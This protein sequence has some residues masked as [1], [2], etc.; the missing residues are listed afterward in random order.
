MLLHQHRHQCPIEHWSGQCGQDLHS[1]GTAS[2]TKPVGTTGIQTL[3]RPPHIQHTGV[4]LSQYWDL[5]TQSS[6]G[7]GVFP[8]THPCS[9]VPTQTANQRRLYHSTPLRLPVVPN[10]NRA[11]SIPSDGPTTATL[12]QS[13]VGTTIG[14][15]ASTT[16]VAHASQAS[17]PT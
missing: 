6:C 2:G 5:H 16:L 3:E 11:P 8:A 9:L 7:T 13:T 12:V 17:S 1:P 10:T 4:S 14:L 15:Y